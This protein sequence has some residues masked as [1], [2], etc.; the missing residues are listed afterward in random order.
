MGKS[1]VRCG[2]ARKHWYCETSKLGY[3]L[4]GSAQQLPLSG[5]KIILYVN[6]LYNKSLSTE[7]II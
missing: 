5:D 2:V 1:R 7:K 4:G 6:S 3:V